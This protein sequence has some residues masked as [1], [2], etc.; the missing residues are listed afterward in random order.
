MQLAFQLARPEF[1]E[2]RQAGIVGCPIHILPDV[3]LQDCGMVGQPIQDFGGGEAV[4]T[5]LKSQAHSV[6]L[7]ADLL[8]DN[9][10]SFLGGRVQPGRPS[11]AVWPGHVTTMTNFTPVNQEK[12]SDISGL[13]LIDRECC[14]SR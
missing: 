4:V 6:V 5:E 11:G 7:A 2:F 12:S 14:R 1:E 3:A 9:S 8:C 13:A 10:R